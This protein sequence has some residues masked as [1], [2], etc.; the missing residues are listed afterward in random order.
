MVSVG[1]G[2]TVTMTLFDLLHP[3]E[4]MVSVTV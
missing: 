3:V 2:F 4:V 1:I